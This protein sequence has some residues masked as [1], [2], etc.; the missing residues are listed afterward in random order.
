MTARLSGSNSGPSVRAGWFLLRAYLYLGLLGCAAWWASRVNSGVLLLLVLALSVPATLALWHRATV[1]TLLSSVQ[2]RQGRGLHWLASR[3]VIARLFG[4]A[5]AVVVCAS[6]VI[7]ASLA[8]PREWLFF[9]SVPLLYAVVSWALQRW[10]SQQFKGAAFQSRGLLVSVGWIVFLIILGGWVC[11]TVFALQAHDQGLLDLV[12]TTQ[13]PWKAAPS[14]LGRVMADAFAWGQAAGNTANAAAR[15]PGWLLVIAI[16]F[17]PAAT[18]AF[19]TLSL[20]GLALPLSE[21]RRV[22]SQ[23]P[24]TEDE[25]PRVTSITAG[26]YA[27]VVVLG[28]LLLVQL[29]AQAEH[30]AKLLGSP[31]A[32]IPLVKCEAIDGKVFKVGTIDAVRAVMVASDLQISAEK[33]KVCGGI[34]EA[35][36]VAEGPVDKY[37]DWYFSLTAEWLRIW[38]ML[39]GDLEQMLA[40]QLKKSLESEK[41][42]ADAL[43]RVNQA[44]EAKAIT[45]EGIHPL[46]QAILKDNELVLDERSCTVVRRDSVFSAIEERQAQALRLRTAGSAGAGLASGALAAKVAAKAMT[47]SSMKAATKVLAKFA[48]KKAAAV[49]ISAA[50]GAFIGSVLPGLGTLLGGAVGTAFGLTIGVGVDWATLA[51][52]EQL[53]RESMKAELLEE[54]ANALLPVREAAGCAR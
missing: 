27:A 41:S 25:P 50:A 28:S 6:A 7:H 45:L 32:V 19:L 49:S 48:A 8:G 15:Q 52:E 43:L 17:A 53:T 37:L 1:R 47:K 5:I 23:G 10:T 44:T 35:L 46:V 40:E 22:F 11:V 39:T 21:V 26:T 54:V 29:T 34:D 30:Q 3:L 36:R 9:A 13:E 31:A 2:F 38:K 24:S 12:A 14:S 4:V 20:N 42:L 51:A 16:V 33:G 18:V